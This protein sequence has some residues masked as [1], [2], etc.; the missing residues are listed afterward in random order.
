MAGE[1]SGKNSGFLILCSMNRFFLQCLSGRSIAAHLWHDLEIGSGA[2]A[3]FN[4]VPAKGSS[5]KEIMMGDYLNQVV[6]ML[7][8]S[9]QDDH[10]QKISLYELLYFQ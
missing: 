2:P 3:V 8:T 6:N 10:P 5:G 9:F 4:C 1:G 7:L